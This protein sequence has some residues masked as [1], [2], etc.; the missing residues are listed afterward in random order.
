MKL[1]IPINVDLCD[2]CPPNIRGLCCYNGTFIEGQHLL[3]TKYPCP[4]LNTITKLCNIYEKRLEWNYCL[5]IEKALKKGC[6]PKEC[7]YVKKYGDKKTNWK[8]KDLSKLSARGLHYYHYI[9]ELVNRE[10]LTY[11]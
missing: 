1:Q 11:V 9:N 4:Y 3:L 5:S 7:L 6:L 8:T 2:N 10:C